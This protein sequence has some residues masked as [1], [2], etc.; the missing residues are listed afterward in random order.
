MGAESGPRPAAPNAPP[1]ASDAAVLEALA[2]EMRAD[3]ARDRVK[4]FAVA[5]PA[6]VHTPAGRCSCVC[7]E[8]H[9][10]DR[11]MAAW[12]E[13]IRLRGRACTRCL[14][15]DRISAFQPYAKLL[16]EC[17]TA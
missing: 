12:R 9:D 6:T 8:A 13:I 17:V 7:I 16:L 1:E 4:A 3:F 11:R 14:E 5:Y 15:R 10:S 2:A